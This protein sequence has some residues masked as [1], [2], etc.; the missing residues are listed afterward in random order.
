MFHCQ[1]LTSACR[2]GLSAS[3]VTALDFA[4][5]PD[6]LWAATSD[7]SLQ[8]FDAKAGVIRRHRPAA[9]AT[10]PKRSLPHDGDA[11][12]RDMHSQRRKLTASQMLQQ[13]GQHRTLLSHAISLMPWSC[14]ALLVPSCPSLALYIQQLRSACCAQERCCT[15]CRRRTG[16]QPRPWRAMMATASW[17]AAAVIVCSSCGRR[18]VSYGMHCRA[19]CACGCAYRRHK[20]GFQKL[21]RSVKDSKS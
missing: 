21:A 12:E 3:A 19:A 8:C 14:H 9:S 5:Q 11:A 15:A 17:S 7:Q 4:Q 16:L 10:A 1:S 18:W 20:A 2:I 6:T 13:H